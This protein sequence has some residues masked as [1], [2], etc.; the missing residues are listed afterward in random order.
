[1]CNV[2]ILRLFYLIYVF[3][4]LDSDIISSCDPA[5]SVEK[6]FLALPFLVSCAN[7]LL[8]SAYFGTVGVKELG[9]SVQC[10]NHMTLGL[11]YS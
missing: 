3:I 11:I 1:M 6:M 2:Y 10:D 5:L 8:S 7:I 4:F 9:V